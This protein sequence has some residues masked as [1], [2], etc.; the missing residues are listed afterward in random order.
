M[1]FTL[2]LVGFEFIVLCFFSFFSK[3]RKDNFRIGL[4]T[5]LVLFYVV[6]CYFRPLN[7]RDTS[8]YINDFN[9]AEWRDLVNI[10]LFGKEPK[11][12]TE[13]GF[14][15]LMLVF[16]SI[17]FSF[18]GFS[19]LISVF[20]M[21]S[22]YA[23]TVCICKH[24]DSS[25]NPSNHEFLAFFA[26]Y[27][28]VYGVFYN[29]VAVRS[30]LSFAF[31]AIAACFLFHKR[32]FI[33]CL[34]I[35]VSFCVQRM[36]LLALLPLLIILLR[37]RFKINRNVFVVAWILLGMLLMVDYWFN[38]FMFIGKWMQD[39]WNSIMETDISIGLNKSD[40]HALKRLLLYLAYWFNGLVYI[41]IF[42]KEKFYNALC[43][44][45]LVALLIS[46]CV[47]GFSASYRIV[48]YLFLFSLPI[49]YMVIKNNGNCIKL[50]SVFVFFTYCMFIL[51]WGL[52]Y[53]QWI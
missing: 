9:N 5:I 46:I 1:E 52:S 29:F 51:S 33:F 31:I 23:F 4:I 16:K 8:V 25:N 34:F 11:S 13:Y 32:Y 50:S 19:A 12:Y 41:S 2:L 47:S 20:N 15:F 17:G 48:D 42:K 30:S 3:I 18:R 35:F 38:S 10:N 45:Y 36:S 6:C 44:I 7:F 26:V 53:Y 27:L 24:I 22:L 28:P 39:I 21:F 43:Y 40:S 14:V 49:N 37:N